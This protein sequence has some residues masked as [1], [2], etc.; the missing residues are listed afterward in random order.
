MHD[1]LLQL[2]NKM[3]GSRKHWKQTGLAAEKK[4]QDAEALAEKAKAKY[5]ALAED[6]DRVKTGDTGAG[7]KF[8]FKGPKSAQQHEEEL[9]RKVQAADQDYFA[10]VQTADGY[11]KELVSTSRPQTVSALV[12]LIR[13]I[14][15]ALT[16]E[17][18]KFGTVSVTKQ[19]LNILL[20]Q[21]VASF[22]EKLI[23]NNGQVVSPQKVK[24]SSVQA[25]S[26]NL[27]IYQINN[28]KDFDEFVLKHRSKITVRSELK[29][30]KHPSLVSQQ[31]QPNPM[32]AAATV[33]DRRPSLQAQTI[34]PV[35]S[36]GSQPRPDTQSP[37]QHQPPPQQQLHQQPVQ[38]PIQQSSYQNYNSGFPPQQQYPP[39]PQSSYPG[40]SSYSPA[41]DNPYSQPS[42]EPPRGPIQQLTQQQST[43][44]M[45]GNHPPPVNP[46]FGVNLEELFVRDETP[47]PLVVYQC[48]QAVDMFGLEVEGIYRIP[49]T[50]SH[51]QA[52]KARF[53]SGMFDGLQLDF[54]R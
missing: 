27:L 43:G 54:N 14:D 32:P 8:G 51:I 17:M 37:S 23:V 41:G 15:A 45:Y 42:S 3:E 16:M 29:Y 53:D 9:Q 6:L 21:V 25:P 22:H 4:V 40:A 1:N 47:V 7:R 10:K 19:Y 13:E 44:V 24:D 30:Q 20:T 36:F 33:G 28:E 49:G 46:V 52:M 50:T 31:Q 5:D 18:Q 11:R 48:I 12:D 39:A 35:P 26:M 38:Q 2:A 34:Q